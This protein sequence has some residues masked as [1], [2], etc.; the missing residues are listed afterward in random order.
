[1]RNKFLHFFQVLAVGVLIRL[2]IS[3]NFYGTD[4]VAAWEGF[5]HYAWNKSPYNAS[6]GYNYSPLWFFVIK[7]CGE[8]AHFTDLPF[9]FVIKLPMIVADV[10]IYKLLSEKWENA[11]LFFL[12]PVSVLCTSYGGQFDCISLLFLVLS[13]FW[14]SCWLS[15]SILAKHFTILL[16]PIFFFAKKRYALLAVPF[17]LSF[18]PYISDIKHIIKQ[19]FLYNAHVGYSE[20]STVVSKLVFLVSGQNIIDN[21]PQTNIVLYLAIAL[22]P[23]FIKWFDIIDKILIVFLTYYVFTTQI[24]PQYY[25]WVL[26]FAVLRPKFLI[27]YSVLSTAHLL[28]FYLWHYFNLLG[29]NPMIA[30]NLFLITKHVLWFGCVA[31]FVS[32]LMERRHG[33]V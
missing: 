22:L 31:W 32:I 18:L 20:L 13:V 10:L 16:L 28:S 19:V 12:N 8:I 30:E 24:A 4:D 29:Q 25:V 17:F 9:H 11:H 3:Y 26:P 7:L 1:M 21:I 6:I 15:L 33:K 2:I 14:N 27:A 23:L 5:S